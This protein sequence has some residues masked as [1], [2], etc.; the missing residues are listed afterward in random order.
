MNSH[1]HRVK[2][3]LQLSHTGAVTAMAVHPDSLGARYA[4]VNRGYFGVDTCIY[5][6]IYILMYQVLYVSIYS[7]IT[8]H[9]I[10]ICRSVIYTHTQHIYLSIYIYKQTYA[11]TYL[12]ILRRAHC[13]IIGMMVT[14]GNHA[15]KN[16]LVLA[17][18]RQNARHWIPDGWC[19]PM[20]PR[21]V[22]FTSP[23]DWT[24]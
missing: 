18:M 23:L 17:W 11:Y 6:Y 16:G 9:I 7:Y 5:I 12:D 13:D 22:V 24:P 2:Q 4:M 1:R 19:L 15:P 10:Q 3:L 21:Q 14:K 8:H 20:R